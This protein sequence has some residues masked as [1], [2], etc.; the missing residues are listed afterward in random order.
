MR[1]K[2][3]LAV[4]VIATSGAM[5]GLAS[6]S[7]AVA[8]PADVPPPS[9][10]Q[11]LSET[12]LVHETWVPEQA[13]ALPVNEGVPDRAWSPRLPE[14]EA[15]RGTSLQRNVPPVDETKPSTSG[16]GDLP[17]YTFMDFP[18]FDADG[19]TSVRVNV[20]SGNLLVQETEAAIAGPGVGIEVQRVFNSLYTQFG[21]I[22]N[23]WATNLGTLGLLGNS[24]SNEVAF[25]GPTG[26]VA[27]FVRAGTAWTA[28][29][30]LNASLSFEANGTGVVRF[31]RTGL[32]YRFVNGWAT[33]I[34][35]RN[36]VG[37]TLA[38]EERG[39]QS[40]T[41]ATGK[42]VLLDYTGGF[43]YAWVGKVSDPAGRTT[44]Y[45][46]DSVTE[47]LTGT[48]GYRGD[49]T[50]ESDADHLGIVT[51]M[52]RS[53][54]KR[55]EFEYDYSGA[56]GRV[57][58]VTQ[59][60][61]GEQD[62]VTSFQ[63]TSTG[64]V[65]T[66]PRGNTSTYEIDGL[67]RSTSAE[68][69][70]GRNRS[71][72]WTPNSDVATSTDAIGS[73]VT[74]SEYDSLNNLSR[75]SLP[76]GAASQAIYAQGV[77]CP[78]AQAGNPYQ[79]KC[80]IDPAG[81]TSS[82]EYD[83]LGNLTK[84]T[85]TT[86]GTTTT[87]QYTYE[88]SAGS[89]CGGHAGQVCTAT[90]AN[91]N[92]T[93]YHYTGGNVTLVDAP[94]PLGD[95]TYEYDSLGR[96]I[97]VTDGNGD[98]THYG[99]DIHD[100]LTSTTYD[101]GSVVLSVWKLDGTLSGQSDS[102]VATIQ[103]F[104]HDL[105]G[106]ITSQTTQSSTP[107][108]I[109]HTET[110]TH[111]IAGNL[112][113]YTEASGTSSYAY[114]VANQLTK[115]T[116]PGG[117][118]PATG[119]PAANS[120]CV[121]FEYDE[122]GAESKRILP[123]GATTV[124]VRDNSGRPTRITAKTGAGA[125]AVDIG[126]SYAAPG[127]G[128]DLTNVQTRTSYKEQGITAGAVTSY[129]YDSHNR[130]TLAQEKVG[131]NVSASWAYVFDA[132]GNRT[133]Q[134]RAGSTGASAGTI[135]YTYNAA[136]QLTSVTGQATTFTYDGVGNQTR[137]GLSGITSA[138]GDRLQ[139]TSTGASSQTYAGGGNA[140]RLASGGT[141]YANTPLGTVQETTGSN[142]K[143]FTFSPKG[144]AIGY[145]ATS[146][147]YYVQDH[148]GSVVG[149]FSSTGTF[150]GGYSY[151]PYGEASATGTAAAVT[152]NP[153]RYIGGRH[154][155]GGIYKLGARYYDTGLGRFTQMD[156]SGQEPNPYS[157]ANADPVNGK[158]PS[159]YETV[160]GDCGLATLE[161]T[162][163]GD[164]T[165]LFNWEL[166]STWGDVIAFTVGVFWGGST[167]GYNGVPGSTMGNIASGYLR[168]VPGT[169][170]FDAWLGG[171]VITTGG[172]CFIAAPHINGTA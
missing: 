19:R 14:E 25:Y 123:A 169:G 112:L 119:N 108:V 155:S 58:K 160:D 97:S 100:R 143:Q 134:T 145:K 146:R 131:A 164:G 103:T 167:P 106:Q 115:L 66:D 35:D 113:T 159:G 76:T 116:E 94:A 75:V 84:Q 168:G 141:S 162:P 99:Y 132:M 23:R 133:S 114:D 144:G 96:L 163:Y 117:T 110:M 148:L 149:L 166:E 13:S 118:C 29:A 125:T 79:A 90:D 128:D 39:L 61:P 89:L 139:L 28:P 54:G 170:G 24:A 70:L 157:Y 10:E 122:N 91:G 129:S 36:G 72:T 78:T 64:T 65:V 142:T 17:G 60:A 22:S 83:T 48:T 73:N 37:L 11:L 121:L 26:Y 2:K 56:S 20:G 5:V 34:A 62:V 156:P 138:F 140:N 67:N 27:R 93:A 82:M 120:G 52:E 152:T 107:G 165:V 111:D 86:S 16:V 46:F 18:F 126:Y 85:N 88:N 31:N 44:N 15:D 158:D 102:K 63:Y 87:Q 33:S 9:A 3:K 1:F 147:W 38:Y 71:Q 55:I 137:N 161:Y 77:N 30:G 7:P 42:Q 105:L 151:S 80:T 12:G 92:V 6:A 127:T 150:A 57:T 51:A 171:T 32:T 95:T 81:N 109:S 136:H 45:E 41:D 135:N 8:V 74:T 172:V 68:D 40:I 53:D 153:L 104:Q 50:M 69:Q 59:K 130:L 21:D 101:D 154:D 4:A 124:T 49:W 43:G 47:S 98:T